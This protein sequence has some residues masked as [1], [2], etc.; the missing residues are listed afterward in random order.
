M[1][2][3]GRTLPHRVR[4]CRDTSAVQYVRF[5]ALAQ[6]LRPLIEEME[7]RASR[8]EHALYLEDVFEVRRRLDATRQS[9][10]S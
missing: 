9:Q 3:V 5:R 4:C 2:T 7:K 8:R 10:G 1:P 6:K